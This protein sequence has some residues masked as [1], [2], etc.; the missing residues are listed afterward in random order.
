MSRF[1]RR[2]LIVIGGAVLAAMLVT[3]LADRQAGAIVLILLLAL[4]FLI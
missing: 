1:G 4:I 3:Y 2:N